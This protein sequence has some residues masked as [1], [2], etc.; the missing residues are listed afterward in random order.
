MDVGLILLLL[1]WHCRRSLLLCRRP[2]PRLCRPRREK[3]TDSG[4]HKC[5]LEVT[6][7]FSAVSSKLVYLNTVVEDE[8][9][10]FVRSSATIWLLANIR[11]SLRKIARLNVNSEHVVWFTLKGT[12]APVQG[13]P[14]C[15]PFT[16]YEPATSNHRRHQNASRQSSAYH[17]RP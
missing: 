1:G 16:G 3:V 7:I 12:P 13:S 4:E 15:R 5:K 11:I 10:S 6:V 14:C 17:A 8:A 2:T 9:D